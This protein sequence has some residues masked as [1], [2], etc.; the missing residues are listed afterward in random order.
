MSLLV[1]AEYYTGLDRD[2]RVL[3]TLD[4]GAIFDHDPGR[5]TSTVVADIRQVNDSVDGVQSLSNE[6]V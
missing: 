4:F 5:W 6:R 1:D 2:D 3:P